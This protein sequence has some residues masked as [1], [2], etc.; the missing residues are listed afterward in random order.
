MNGLRPLTEFEREAVTLHMQKVPVAEIERKT[1][2]SA[3]AI[4]AAVDQA[5]VLAQALPATPSPPALVAA[6]KPLS[7]PKPLELPKAAPTELA[8]EDV[9]PPDVPAEE[10]RLYI[11]DPEPAAPDEPIA[12]LLARAEASLQPRVRQLAA[13]VRERLAEIGQRIDQDEKARTLT[14][15]AEVLRRQL[16]D[17]EAELAA[18]LG[19][20]V[21]APAPA[22]SKPA[23][24]STSAKSSAEDVDPDV[25]R[26]WGLANGWDVKPFGRVPGAVRTAYIAAHGGSA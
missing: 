19:D 10:D 9:E 2:L 25:L 11:E 8:A 24:Q 6:R 21:V 15:A 4:A 16:A 1:G 13:D 7:F 5:R 12:A 26:T 20:D 18:L 22:E 14:I 23:A 3:P 17:T